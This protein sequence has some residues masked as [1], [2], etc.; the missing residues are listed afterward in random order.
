MNGDELVAE[1][2]YA[3]IWAVPA[4][5]MLFGLNGWFIGMQ[6]ARIP[7]W[8]AIL[9]KRRP[10]RLFVVLRLPLRDGHRR[11]RLRLGRRPVCSAWRWP[12]C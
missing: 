2:F 10:C 7:M 1:Y 9:Q 4:G 8:I 3:R 11:H 6:N 5:I 12:P